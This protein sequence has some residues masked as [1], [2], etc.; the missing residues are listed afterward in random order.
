MSEIV[1]NAASE[2]I[3]R[4]ALE[5]GFDLVGIARATPS[6]NAAYLREWLA[7]GQAGNMAWLQTHVEK[8]L[9]VRELMPGARSLVCVAKNY[10]Y[11]L[12]ASQ[13]GET[14]RIARYALGDDYHDVMKDGLHALAD[15]IREY[16][17]GVATKCGVDSSPI[18]EREFA[19]AAGVGWIGKNTCVIHPGMGS[20][21][22]L[23]EVITTADL[24]PDRPVADHCG[25]CTRCLDACPTGAITGPR[26]LDA[27][28][29]ISYLTIEHREPLGT[30]QQA[31]IGD[32]L[33]GCDICQEVCPYNQRAPR[34]HN[35]AVSAPLCVGA[36]AAFGC[37]AD[38][39]S[40]A[41][42]GVSQERRTAC[43]AADFAGECPSGARQ[44]FETRIE[45]GEGVGPRLTSVGD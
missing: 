29:C 24:E 38:G 43:E 39:R 44:S 37:A 41:S 7:S 1:T 35:G 9:D 22:F 14:G 2:R 26:D 36:R 33:I 32:W 30:D 4:E 19:A 31:M 28:K 45:K 20:W 18:L 12:E 34:E 17:P 6:E 23:G 8:L 10:H 40:G 3:K 13:G 42:R 25:S 11:P 21:L 5:L 16:L 27:R 15:F